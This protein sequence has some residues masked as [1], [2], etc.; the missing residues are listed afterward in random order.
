[1]NQD[2]VLGG[3]IWPKDIFVELAMTKDMQVFTDLQRLVLKESC[4]LA[5]VLAAIKDDPG[6]VNSDVCS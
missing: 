1:M 5:T 3:L 4:G 6:A 2:Y